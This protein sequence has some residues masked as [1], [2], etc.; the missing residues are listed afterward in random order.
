MYHYV[1]DPGDA[2]DNSSGI[3]GLPVSTF[4]AQL[5]YLG[6]N[7]E[8]I[9]WPD[10]RACLSGARSLPSRAC[11]L[12][13]DD[14]VRDHYLNVFPVLSSRNMPGLFFALARHPSMG[15][16]L[17]HKIHFLIARLGFHAL[18][19]V[20]YD[21]LDGIQQVAFDHAD[22]RY[23]S[24]GSKVSD[25]DEIEVFKLA[26]Q[27]DLSDMAEPILSQ[28]I[29]ETIGPEEEIAREFFLNRE[30]VVEMAD[31]GMH[32]GGH[33]HSHPWFDWVDDQRQ[34]EEIAVSGR[35]LSTFAEGPWAFAYP[36][37]GLD[38]RSPALLRANGFLGAFT[39]I[40]QAAHTDPFYIG[41]YDAESFTPELIA[42]GVMG[43]IS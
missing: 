34:A 10:L 25:S 39:T 28:L 43:E 37:G 23:R 1:R 36:Y 32:F 17:G 33:S 38:P 11:L 13:F 29:V 42:G 27:R 16:T 4:E 6:A 40:P 3:P 24:P 20:F 15:L 18:R 8:M 35:W 30:Q 26:L 19:S 5:D 22:A 7:F 2:A 9:A 12:T 41:R 14:G 31:G 21:R